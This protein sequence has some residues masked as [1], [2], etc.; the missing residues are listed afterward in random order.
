MPGEAQGGGGVNNLFELMPVG[1]VA[2][3]LET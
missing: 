3:V 2:M 1:M